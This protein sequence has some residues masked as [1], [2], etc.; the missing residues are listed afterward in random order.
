MYDKINITILT[1]DFILFFSN[2]FSI[3]EILILDEYFGLKA[4]F[5]E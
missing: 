1:L 5:V 3:K 4:K 2:H